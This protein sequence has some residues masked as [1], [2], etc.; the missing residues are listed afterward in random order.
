MDKIFV[1]MLFSVAAV[2]IAVSV[3]RYSPEASLAVSVCAGAS[4]LL[5]VLDDAFEIRSRIASLCEST[6]IDGDY[7]KTVTKIIFIGLIGQ[8]GASLARDTNEASV[9]EKTEVAVKIIITAISLPYIERLFELI[10]EI[11]A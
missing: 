2:F 5:F 3:K 9:A 10:K 4:I 7:L 1:I 6:L 11:V 8:W